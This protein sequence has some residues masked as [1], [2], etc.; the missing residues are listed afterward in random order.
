MLRGSGE[1]L[2]FERD[3]EFGERDHFEH[4]AYPRMYFVEHEYAGDP[5]NWWVPN[6]AAAAAMLR[7][8]GFAIVDNP[9][10]EVFICR[11]QPELARHAGEGIDRLAETAA[12]L[13]ARFK[14][15]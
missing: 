13:D 1:C 9:E 7:S 4:P 2:E 12:A 6:R 8:S 14:E 3:Y 11:R 15:R 5:T 10:E